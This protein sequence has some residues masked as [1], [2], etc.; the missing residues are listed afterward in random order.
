MPQSKTS[1]REAI[2]VSSTHR[3]PAGIACRVGVRRERCHERMEDV[4]PERHHGWSMRIVV[5]EV[6]AESQDGIGIWS[7]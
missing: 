2:T 3:L 1:R 6:D 4:T 5:G 7:W